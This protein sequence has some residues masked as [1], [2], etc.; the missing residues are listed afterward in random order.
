L[1]PVLAFT[2]QHIDVSIA[3]QKRLA[4]RQ[5][6]FRTARVRAPEVPFD[7]VH[8]RIARELLDRALALHAEVGWQPR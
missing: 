5:G 7:A 6:I 4:V 8:E 3:F 1:L 2:S